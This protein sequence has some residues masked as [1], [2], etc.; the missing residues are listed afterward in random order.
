MLFKEMGVYL[1]IKTKEKFNRRL[2]VAQEV[3]NY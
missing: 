2:S 3:T 1:R